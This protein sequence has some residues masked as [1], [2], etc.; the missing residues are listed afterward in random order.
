MNSEKNLDCI[1]SCNLKKI[2]DLQ[3]FTDA[4]QKYKDTCAMNEQIFFDFKLCL[5]EVIVNIFSHGYKES[6]ISPNINLSLYKSQDYFTADI[7]D[8]GI[9]FNPISDSSPIN[10]EASLEERPIGGL[11][12]HLLKNLS[13]ELE[14]IPQSKGNQLKIYKKI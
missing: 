14:Y 6:K 4:F 3:K 12:I 5:E 11:G 2:E 10:L 1:L 7:T 13:D 9:F 8:N